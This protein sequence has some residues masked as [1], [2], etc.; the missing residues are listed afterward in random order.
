MIGHTPLSEHRPGLN[1]RLDHLAAYPFARLADLLADVAPP[2][3]MKPLSMVV[4]EPQRSPPSF[5]HEVMAAHWQDWNK[6]PLPIGT[7][8]FRAAAGDWLVRRYGLPKGRFDPD[9]S[10][11]PVTGTREALFQLAL[12]VVSPADG[13]ATPVVLLPN[14]LYPVYQGA[15]LIAGAEPVFLDATAETG[16]LP[17]LT[18]IPDSVLERTVL[19]YLCTPANPQGAIADSAYLEQA[20]RLARHHGFV[21]AVD[22]CY[23]EI[24]GHTPPI[25]ALTVAAA[26]D[27]AGP[28][29]WRNLVVLHSLSKRSSAAGMRSGFIAGD[30]TVIGAF[31]RLRSYSLAGTPLPLLAAA[32]ALWRDEDHVVETRARYR[33]AFDAAEAALGQHPGFVRPPAGFFLWLEVGDGERMAQRLW[34]EQGVRVLP[35]AYVTAP[36]PDGRNHGAPFVRIALVHDIPIVAD[37]CR[38]IAQLLLPGASPHL[39]SVETP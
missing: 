34:A 27:P 2:H 30:P 32:A 5:I 13:G 33:A 29:P 16:H 31:Q 22:E 28:A 39:P 36:S 23:A 6:Y 7:K 10:L 38:R 12:L 14:P 4:G 9:T 26:L 17:D 15:G 24:Y 37:A 21:L 19:F 8:D 1:R 35:G 11:L 20:I 25:G 18:A 3:G